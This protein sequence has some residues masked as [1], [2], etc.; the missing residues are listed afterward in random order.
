MGSIMTE[1]AEIQLG[2]DIVSDGTSEVL[3]A[4]ED[5]Q[6]FDEIVYIV[7]LGDVDAAAVM[8]FTPKENTASSTSSPTPTAVTLTNIAGTGATISSG[9]ATITED[10]GN[11]DDKI[12]VITVSGSAISNRYHFLSITVADESFEVDSIITIKR[13]A[14][15]VPVTQPSDV[16]L[17]ASA[18]S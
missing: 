9:A 15:G 17:H 13:K 10:T 4:V 18:Q 11:L 3:T 6:G 7:K 5:M 1:T 12:I 8:T 2:K 14:S 16:A